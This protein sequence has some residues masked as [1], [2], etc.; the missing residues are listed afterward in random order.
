MSNELNNSAEFEEYT[1][2]ILEMS[3][4]KNLA[5]VCQQEI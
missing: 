5:N 2:F 3:D 4:K 1:T